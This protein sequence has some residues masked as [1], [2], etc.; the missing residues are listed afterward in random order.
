[1]HK[2]LPLTA[3]FGAALALAIPTSVSIAGVPT[4][5][6]LHDTVLG[7]VGG[8]RYAMDSAPYGGSD[9]SANVEAGCGASS[10]HLIGGG[11]LAGGSA[12]LAWQS[13]DRGD[14]YTDADSNP[15]DGFL[16]GGYGPAGKTFISYSICAKNVSLEYPYTTVPNQPTHDRT[17]T[18][19][20]SGP[21]WRVTTGSV[22]IATTDSWA[23]TSFPIDGTDAD[24]TRDDGWK[25]TAYDTIGGMGGY[26]ISAICAKGLNLRYVQKAG[27]TLTTGHASRVSVSCGTGHVVGGGVNVTGSQHQTR[28]VISA[29]YD[30]SDADHI[31]DDGWLSEVY[32]VSGA[33]RTVTAYAICV[34]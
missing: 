5:P 16:A 27:P 34:G 21:N 6:N 26:S 15:D 8:L 22:A 18:A 23:T 10:S 29:P 24:T 20:C 33:S 25:G 19:K 11:A 30:G 32:G 7:T 31:P 12:S 28:L 4:D 17:G 2:L 1:M 9:G 14:D 3:V 13:F